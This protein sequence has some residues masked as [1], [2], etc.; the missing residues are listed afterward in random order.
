MVGRRRERARVETMRT[1]TTNSSTRLL[2]LLLLAVLAARVVAAA[3]ARDDPRAATA[4]HR[5]SFRS[6]FRALDKD[7]DGQIER[8]ELTD[9]I[10]GVGGDDFD[11]ERE[12]RDAVRATTKKIDGADRGDGISEDE[13]V[14]H[15]TNPSN[16]LLVPHNVERWVRHG[17]SFP[18]YADAFRDNAVTALDFPALI[19]DDAKALREDLGIS[20]ALHRGQFVRA[21]K[22]Q[23]LGL[24][25]VPSEPRDLKTSAV[26]ASAVAIRW[27]PPARLGT[28][29]T[30]LYVVKVQAGNDPNWHTDGIVAADETHYVFSSAKIAAAH[31]FEVIAWG[32]HGASEKRVVSKPAFVRPAAHHESSAKRRE[33]AS[34]RGG[35]GAKAGRLGDDDVLEAAGGAYASIASTFLVI[36]LASRFLLSGAAFVGGPGTMRAAAWRGM[37]FVLNIKG[38]RGGGGNGERVEGEGGE[39]TNAAAPSSPPPAANGGRPP[40]SSRRPEFLD[41]ALKAAVAA[42]VA[43]QMSRG[44]SLASLNSRDSDGGGGGGGGSTRREDVVESPGSRAATATPSSPPVPESEPK[45]KGRCCAVG[46]D[47]RWDRWSVMGDIKMKMKKHFC[48]LCQRAYCQTHTA[49]SPH[50]GR[51]RCDPESKCYCVTCHAGLDDATKAALEMTNKLSRGAGKGGKQSKWRKLKDVSVAPLT[52]SSS[53]GNLDARLEC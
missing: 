41:E 3:P 51:G 4:A 9:A 31:R 5:R 28:P 15:L 53:A 47:A 10:R 16:A 25:A 26:N 30:H 37:C 52:P 21:L 7:D 2:L 19:A 40:P 44:N 12:I 6:F 50:G 11:T 35:A 38:R 23:I 17:L 46:C 49:V 45:K 18:R 1:S 14:D 29:P 13:L 22:R 42:G 8:A 36:G 24:G 32:A 43:P 33:D 20:S 34:E 39:R 48:G 27:R